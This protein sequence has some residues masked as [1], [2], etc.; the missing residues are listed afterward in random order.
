MSVD[1]PNT[2]G[3]ATSPGRTLDGYFVDLA[4]STR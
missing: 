2:I 3:N 1:E 4:A